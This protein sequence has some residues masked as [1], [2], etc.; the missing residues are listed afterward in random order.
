MSPSASRISQ[1]DRSSQRCQHALAFVFD[2]ALR[3]HDLGSR[4]AGEVELHGER[5]GEQ[6]RVA[7]GDTRPAAFTH[8]NLDDAERFQ[9][10][11]RVACD[12]PADTVSGSLVSTS[13]ELAADQL[14]SEIAYLRW[15]MAFFQGEVDRVERGGPVARTAAHPGE[16]GE[17]EGVAVR[18]RV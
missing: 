18:A 12:D 8:A 2:G 7:A 9:R 5:F 1:S 14:A 17:E 11:Q 6:A 13:L 10:A 4:H 15:L 3:I 16:L